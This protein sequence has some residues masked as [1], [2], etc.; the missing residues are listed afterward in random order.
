M[1]IEDAVHGLFNRPTNVAFSREPGRLYY[2]NYGGFELGALP[3]SEPGMPL[4]Y[5]KLGEL[6]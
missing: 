5:P 6:G 4:A 2:A 1:L 3:V